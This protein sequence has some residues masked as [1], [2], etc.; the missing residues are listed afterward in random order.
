MDVFLLET[1][2][3]FSVDLTFWLQ[4]FSQST[5]DIIKSLFA[6][7]GWT[8][9][10]NIFFFMGSVLWV[11]YRQSKYTAKW[12]WVLLAVDIP[13]LYIQ[14]PKAVE[15]IFAHLSGAKTSPNVGEKFW[16][17]K[18]QKWFS[19]EIVS[20]DGYIQFLVRCESEFRDLVEAAI[21]AQYVEAEIT[22]VEDYTNILPHHFPNDKMDIFGIEFGLAENEAFPIRTYPSFEYNISKDLVFSDPMAAILENFSRI[23]K[24]ENFWMQIIVEPTNNAW[25]KHGIELV[26][27]LIAGKGEVVHHHHESIVSK[28]GDLPMKIGQEVLNIWNWSFEAAHEEHAEA[29]PEGK[30][31]DLS[32]GSKTT[33][34]AIEQKLTKIGFKTKVRVLYVAQK[35]MFNPGRCIDG[36]IGALNQ[37]HVVSSNALVPHEVTEKH[38]M[39]KNYRLG[40]M[41]HHF[42]TMFQKRKIKMGGNPYVLNI[43][44]LA[45][46]WHF[47]LPFVKTP[48]MQKS[49]T[50]R[51]EPPMNL[52]LEN[53]NE[54][55]TR[56]RR[57]M[58]EPEPEPTEE[59]P[60]E[61]LPYG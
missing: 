39:F 47:P 4:L 33:L 5:G 49:E 1:P 60:P 9:L 43:E 16:K 44:E 41:K 40:I 27:E 54:G 7:G 61:E 35:E 32:P 55:Q 46:I 21:Y 36:M 15:Q 34:E 3:G 24:G 8:I 22:E 10:A 20:I 56:L 38:Y 19:F 13:P 25:K 48:L 11:A 2:F 42:V 28:F 29:A 14:T 31:Q 26:K 12:K 57:I 17:G 6:I 45:T 18:K 59:A 50:K 37:F 52:P 58:P 23:G 53:A 30:V 51:G